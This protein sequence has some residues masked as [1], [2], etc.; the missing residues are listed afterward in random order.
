MVDIKRLLKAPTEIIEDSQ[1]HLLPFPLLG[2]PKID[3]F[4]CAIVN[5]AAKTSSMKPQPNPFVFSELSNSPELNG[6]DGELVVGPPNDIKI[7]NLSTGVL[8][9]KYG[10]PDFTFY[11]FDRC[12]HPEL[13]YDRRWL[14]HLSNSK[15]NHPR[16]KILQQTVLHS[17]T[18]VIKFTNQCIAANFEGAMIRTLQGKYKQNRATFNEMNIFKRKIL[19]DAEATII[20]FVEKQTNLNPKITDKMGLTKRS[21]CKEGKVGAETLGSFLLSSEKWKK[22]F[23]CRGKI[24]DTLA[25]EIW[26]N[27]EKYLGK[28]VTYKYQ[29]YGSLEAPRQPVFHRFYEEI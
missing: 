20:G 29:Q 9:R 4:R 27:K 10:E 5:Q 26:N 12:V 1:L 14:L 8:R 23:N 3:G 17:S 11:V 2:S 28:V 21:S 19:T 24:T 6:L 7:F 15:L 18:D 25:Q 16:I 22:P 13:P